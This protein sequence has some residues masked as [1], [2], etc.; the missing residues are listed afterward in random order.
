MENQNVSKKPGKEIKGIWVL[1]FFL[2]AL[3]GVIVLHKLTSL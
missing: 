3:I 2:F 1:L